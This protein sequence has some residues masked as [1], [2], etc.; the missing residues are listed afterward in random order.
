MGQTLVGGEDVAGLTGETGRGGKR[1]AGQT[2]MQTGQ[3][4]ILVDN[5]GQSRT[6]SVCLTQVPIRI[7]PAQTAATDDCSLLTP[8]RTCPAS[9]RTSLTNP[10]ALIA[11]I[12]TTALTTAVRPQI[13]RR[14]AGR[15]DGD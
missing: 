7:V 8:I 9:H 5:M 10:S 12:E 15:T 1:S 6:I 2:G 13:V 4:M 3:T 11:A 14:H